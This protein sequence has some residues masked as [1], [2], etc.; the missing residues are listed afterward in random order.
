MKV[1]IVKVANN[2]IFV[3]QE[4]AMA[5]QTPT[6]SLYYRLMKVVGKK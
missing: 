2:K 6:S 3:I 5:S 1:G 4:T